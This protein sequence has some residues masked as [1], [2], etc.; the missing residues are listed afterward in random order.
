[1]EENPTVQVYTP[2]PDY[3]AGSI[4][5]KF[6]IL[7]AIA[8]VLVSSAVGTGIGILIAKTRPTVS[9][10]G[11]GNIT[12]ASVKTI[13]QQSA[14]TS[15]VKNA[16][17][18]VVSIIVSQTVQNQLNPFNISGNSNGSSTQEVAA[19]SG[20]IVSSNGYI[21]TN[22]HV[23]SNTTDTYS[24]ELTT[25]KSYAAQVVYQDP[26][27]D[28]AIMKIH[29]TGLPTLSLGDSSNLELGQTVIAI[30]NALGQ[31]QNTVDTGVVSGV[32]R[33]IT[34]SEEG[35]GPS[36]TLNNIIQ[37]DAEINSGNSGGPLLNI[38][39]Q[40]IGINTAVAQ[41]AQGIGFAIPINQAR[42][43]ISRAEQGSVNTAQSNTGN[44]S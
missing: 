44:I 27:N 12:T 40:V 20:F 7:I 2:A 5:K 19:G 35:S 9:V 1:M 28:I 16:N 33:T 8:S 6:L 38:T 10:L 3:I 36:E 41:N 13:N 42:D 4:V 15:V 24:V 14:I 18:A 30:G 21:A 23:A 32:N 29:A 22:K 34:A 43:D 17:P 25:G 26:S 31:Y 37:T 11:L 39:G